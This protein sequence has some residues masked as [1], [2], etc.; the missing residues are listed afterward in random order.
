MNLKLQNFAE[1]SFRKPLATTV[2][3]LHTAGL[4]PKIRRLKKSLWSQI[5]KIGLRYYREDLKSLPELSGPFFFEGC[6]RIIQPSDAKRSNLRVSLTWWKFAKT[7]PTDSKT[8]NFGKCEDPRR[9]SL[10]QCSCK[11]VCGDLSAFCIICCFYCGRRSM[12]Y[13]ER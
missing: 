10:I 3:S 6:N 8:S 13:H 11:V 12:Q 7:C 5:A 4:S 9:K 2:L 1:N